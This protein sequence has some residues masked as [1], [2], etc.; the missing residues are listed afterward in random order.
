MKRVKKFP[1][2]DGELGWY[3][4]ASNLDKKIGKRLKGK[5]STDF[6]VVGAG[7]AGIAVASRLKELFPEKSIALVE[8]LDVGQGTSGRN[9]GF[10]IDLPHNV[11]KTENSAE[12]D[13]QIYALNCFAIQK[14]AEKVEKFHI[15]CNW[16]KAGKYMAARETHNIAGLD[17]FETMLKKRNFAYERIKGDTLAAK[18]GTNYYQEA[19]FTPDN[20]LMNPAA[21]VRGLVAGLEDEGVTVYS[22]SPVIA[23]NYG[24]EN[25]L[26]T[27]GGELRAKTVI[28]TMSSFTEENG[29]VKSKIAPLF[30]YG[31]LTGVLDDELWN[32]HFANIEPWGLTS[33]HPA[34]T[35]VRITPDRRIFIR[36]ILEYNRQQKSTAAMRQY[37]WRH[38]RAAFLARFPF[39]AE[40]DFEYTWGG[41]L[42]VTRNRQGV[43]SRL[44]DNVY[45]LCACN[46]V[47][48][49]KGTYSGYY[50]A[51][52][53]AG[54][55]SKE[56]EF[57]EKTN[58]PNFMPPE[59]FRG[60]GAR[61][62]I[63]INQRAAGL[64]I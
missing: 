13:A 34:G 38:H 22:N 37:C 14:L 46:G 52:K 18:L 9:A 10:V 40:I 28:T 19:I 33:A 35:T 36:N 3:L 41:I 32:K 17:E 43:F 29:L 64:D 61:G 49:A 62:Q 4:T 59:P 27:V 51:D 2:I 45:A 24:A 42:A 47:G 39:L 8:A 11:D 54:I 6:A 57:I 30:T 21:L 48:V 58:N 20:I 60:I 25:I 7:F 44:R 16:H 63:Y 5:Q 55:N 26:Q 15:D 56:L 12:E 31:S 50:L 23:F 53:I 1:Q